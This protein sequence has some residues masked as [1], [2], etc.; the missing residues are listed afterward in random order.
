MKYIIGW[1]KYQVKCLVRF[2]RDCKRK[3]QLTKVVFEGYDYDYAYFYA[4]VAQKLRN[5]L[6]YQLTDCYVERPKAFIDRL[7]I[8]IKLCDH[9]SEKEQIYPEYINVNNARRHDKLNMVY[10]PNANL[11]EDSIV[12][13]LFPGS[14]DKFDLNRVYAEEVYDLKAKNIVHDFLNNYLP[15]Y[16]D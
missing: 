12:K 5:V 2:Y 14:E 4:L 11:N 16:G 10:M 3:I 1:L 13:K 15:F 8:I 9:L 6:D 7:E